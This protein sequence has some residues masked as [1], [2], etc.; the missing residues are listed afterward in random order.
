MNMIKYK[1]NELFQLL[2]IDLQYPKFIKEYLDYLVAKII[3][4]DGLILI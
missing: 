4:R 3:K 2:S 1:L